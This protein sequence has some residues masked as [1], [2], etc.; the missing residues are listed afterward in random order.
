MEQIQGKK[1]GST[2]RVLLVTKGSPVV[3]TFVV[4]CISVHPIQVECSISYF[5]TFRRDGSSFAVRIIISS[6]RT[7]LVLLISAGR[8]NN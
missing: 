6:L 7:Q 1:I 5:A 8:G 3:G 4:H 2:K